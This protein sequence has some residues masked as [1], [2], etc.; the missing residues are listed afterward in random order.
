MGSGQ[1]QV[2]IGSSCSTLMVREEEGA[3][4]TE[5]ERSLPRGNQDSATNPTAFLLNYTATLSPS[6]LL[7]LLHSYSM[8]APL[9][10]LCLTPFEPISGLARQLVTSHGL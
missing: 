10:L 9:C 6:T 7:P 3:G 1:G 5:K 4:Q 2:K 8:R